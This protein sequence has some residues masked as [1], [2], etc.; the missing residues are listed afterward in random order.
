M[1]RWMLFVLMWMGVSIAAMADSQDVVGTWTLEVDTPRGIQHPTL[2]I[3]SS[4]DSYHG[5]YTG[6]RGELKIEQIT[7][8]GSTFS[9]PLKVTLP[10]GEMDFIYEGQVD[11]DAMT[12]EIGNPR[13][14]IPFSGVRAD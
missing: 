2:E 13:G 9:F 8:D 14:T 4:G 5:S 7:V 3:L 1:V 10:M 12:G 6:Q 11:G